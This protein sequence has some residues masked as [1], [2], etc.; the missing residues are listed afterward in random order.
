[1]TP[2]RPKPSPAEKTTDAEGFA[3]FRALAALRP[4]FWPADR[5]DLRLRLLIAFGLLLATKVVTVIA[6]YGFKWAT[7]ALTG[8]AGAADPETWIAVALASPV[9]MVVA[10]GFGR[11]MMVALAQARDGVAAPVV[12]NAV[13]KLALQVFSH[14]HN[15]SLRYHLTRRT[16]LV[17]RVV[18]RGRAAIETLTRT[19]LLTIV[20][21]LIEIVLVL[22]VLLRQFDWRYVA[23]VAAM[24]AAYLAF[25]YAVTEWRLNIR[26]ELNDNDNDASS[27]AIDSLLNYETVKYF[28]AEAREAERY[29][30]S[31][32][33]YERASIRAY[34]SLAWLNGGQALIFAAGLTL[35]MVMAVGDIRAGR[36]TVGDFVLINALLVQ[37]YVPLNFMGFIYREIKQS[38][39]DL[40]ALFR[41]LEQDAE[42]ADRPGAAPLQTPAGAIR[43]EAVD[44]SY[45]PERAILKD[46]SFEVRPGAKVAIVGPTGAGKSTISRLLFRFYDVTS[47][48]V[49]IDGQDIRDVTQTSLRAAIGMVP[50]DT[51]LFNETI[52]YNIRYGRWDATDAEVERAAALAQIDGFIRSLPDGY[53][54]EVGERGLKLSGGEKQRIAIAR[55]IL[56]G[57]PILILDEA[58][59]ALDSAT[60]K[61]IQ[62]ALGRVAEGRTTLVIAHRLSTIVDADEI[63]VLEAGRVVERG[64]HAALLAKGGVY[65]GLWLRQSEAERARETLARAGE[66]AFAAAE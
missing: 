58:T 24:V 44:F 27:K 5:P 62:D 66:D 12:M 2:A 14:I 64:A 9:I 28:G 21:T 49:T 25:T 60:E 30:R 37:L 41:L 8:P 54:T 4:F 11:V 39:T 32:A 45:D 52:R 56:K 38:V 20:P 55:T 26:R 17:S 16:G 22:L 1:M 61:D 33:R 31:M 59:S 53:D 65:A 23:V 3:L 48:R 34:T 7:D 50:Q 29:D 46:V 10:Y 47:G 63:L 40:E 43:F 19:G 57:P 13:R 15:L 36:N 18:D 42:I 35:C 6:P 51:V